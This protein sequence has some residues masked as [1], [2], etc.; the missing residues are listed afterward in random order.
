MSIKIHMKEEKAAE[1]VGDIKP[2]KIKIRLLPDDNVAQ[3]VERRRDNPRAM[4]RILA[5]VSFLICSVAFF[6]LCYPG[7][8]LQDP[9]STGVCTI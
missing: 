1:R 8:A 9:F 2:M 6:L 3:S 7:E 5:S 4:D